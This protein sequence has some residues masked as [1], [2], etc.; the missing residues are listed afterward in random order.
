MHLN[1]LYLNELTTIL[2]IA[3]AIPA[4]ISIILKKKNP[5][6]VINETNDISK[7]RPFRVLPRKTVT[8]E[9]RYKINH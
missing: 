7:L 8:S 1:I 5:S 2:L 6:P 9:I 3:I 4:E